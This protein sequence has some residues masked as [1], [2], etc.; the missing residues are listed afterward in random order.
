MVAAILFVA[1]TG[2]QWRYLPERY[3]P[4]DTVRQQWRCWRENGVWA[5]AMVRIAHPVRQRA[6]R[7]A[8]S[9]RR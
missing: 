9:R 5:R 2:C 4:S 8:P 6:K 1:R 7:R 3:P